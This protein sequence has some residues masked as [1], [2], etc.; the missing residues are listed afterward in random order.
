MCFELD[1]VRP[2]AWRD[3]P[4]PMR[5][6]DTVSRERLLLAAAL[7]RAGAAYTAEP[8]FA[9]LR[10]GLNALR[11]RALERALLLAARLPACP[12]VEEAIRLEQLEA[13]L[14]AALRAMPG[15]RA[16]R[17]ALDFA[18]PEEADQLYRFAN[19]LDAEQDAP[20]ERVTGGRT[21]ITPGRP[22]IAAHRHPCDS[23][24]PPLDFDTAP[25][26]ALLAV[27]L[28][29]PLQRHVASLYLQR[30]GETAD[31]DVRALFAEMALIEEQHAA[32]Y[33]S[34]WDPRR[35]P[36]ENLPLR[37][38]ALCYAYESLGAAETDGTLRA[39]WRQN[40]SEARRDLDALGGLLRACA[41]I[42]PD[43][44]TEAFP[45]PFLF[46]DTSALVR[47]LMPQQVTLT[48][49]ED[50]LVP[51]GLLPADCR[52]FAWQRALNGSGESTP[53]HRAVRRYAARY[54]T[55]YRFERGANPIEALQN[56][57]TDNVTLGCEP[58]AAMRTGK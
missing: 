19:L 11:R 49:L 5:R 1:E 36:L 10:R 21:E 31:A 56:R 9:D 15:T 55:D 44:R 42:E 57:R 13:D 37:A 17:P 23:A 40:L 47:A 43:P 52:Y 48:M 3:Y 14:T 50:S 16:V 35:T 2:V 30:A 6:L 51:S 12:P 7:E 26:A 8:V 54:G 22:C 20:A 41:G 29:A 45:P 53:S 58:L 25:R 38:E 27:A 39:L 32:Q 24:F 4:R 33:E 34:L 28:M 18:L 46:G